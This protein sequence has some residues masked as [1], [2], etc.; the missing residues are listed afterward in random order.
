[1][2][3]TIPPLRQR[4]LKTSSETDIPPDPS[5]KASGMTLHAGLEPTYPRSPALLPNFYAHLLCI[6]P[7][8]TSRAIVYLFPNFTHIHFGL[9]ALNTGTHS[10]SWLKVEM[11]S[12]SLTCVRLKI[13]IKVY[14]RIFVKLLISRTDKVQ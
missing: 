10:L 7:L 8:L 1:M 9:S 11:L 14:L 2:S 12:I 6:R 13:V 4:Q 5:V 3:L